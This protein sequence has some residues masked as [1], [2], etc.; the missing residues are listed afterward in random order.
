M[1]VH[2]LKA[3]L[4]MQKTIP[5]NNSPSGYSYPVPTVPMHDAQVSYSTVSSHQ[6]FGLWLLQLGRSC[7]TEVRGFPQCKKSIQHQLDYWSCLIADSTGFGARHNP[8]TWE[9][10]LRLS[11][12]R[13]QA[14]KRTSSRIK[15]KDDKERERQEA[16]KT[17]TITILPKHPVQQR[18]ATLLL[19][20]LSTWSC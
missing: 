15:H 7:A 9:Q 20:V 3:M 5:W 4:S 19:S 18:N 2:K 17:I 12:N 10:F 1:Q 13:S 6:L 16:L 14:F 11:W 8:I